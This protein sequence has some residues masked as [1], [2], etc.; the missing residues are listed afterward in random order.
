MTKRHLLLTVIL[1][2][3]AL[4]PSA[5]QAESERLVLKYDDRHIQSSKHQ[6]ATIYLKQELQ[7]SYPGLDLSRQ[8][9]ERI[10]VMAKSK[11]GNGTVQLRVND[12]YSREMRVQ[13]QSNSFN[14]KDTFNYD[15]IDIASPSSSR[16]GAWQLHFRGNFMLRKIV[17]ITRQGDDNYSWH[18]PGNS[19]HHIND[20]W[21][22]D[23]ENGWKS[24]WGNNGN[25]NNQNGSNNNWNNS[26]HNRPAPMVLGARSWGT[27]QE[28]PR[29]CGVG[30]SNVPDGWDYPDSICQQSASATF[31]RGYHPV[32]LYVIPDAGLLHRSNRRLDITQLLVSAEIWHGGSH[33]WATI[34]LDIGGRSY[35]RQI[36]FRPRGKADSTSMTVSGRWS[37]NQLENAR[38][39]I[40]P[41]QAD[42]DIT[43][44]NLR[45]TV[46]EAG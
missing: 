30:S 46:K 9:L 42:R 4:L 29:H 5:V 3:L 20:D 13:G 21:D 38:A 22:G 27:N 37:P 35:T 8:R 7:R 11:K 33:G 14:N 31:R 43:V 44:R 32:R 23:R 17:V 36:N 26:F 10:V 45:I 25:W 15:K 18:K 41:G 34:R 2:V 24:N 39:W 16:G 6:P 40:L 12:D 19:N 28:G 1:T